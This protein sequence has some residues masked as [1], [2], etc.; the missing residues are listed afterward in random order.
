M[1]CLSMVF[2]LVGFPPLCEALKEVGWKNMLAKLKLG[3]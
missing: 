3:V 2:S 1:T